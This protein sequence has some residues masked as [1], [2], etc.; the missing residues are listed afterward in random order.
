[1]EHAGHV[2]IDFSL[3]DGSAKALLEGNLQII[4]PPRSVPL[5]AIRGGFLTVITTEV[6]NG[7]GVLAGF[8]CLL[9]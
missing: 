9:V 4:D 7:I 6:L 8:K 5:Q 1:M 2:V 3:P